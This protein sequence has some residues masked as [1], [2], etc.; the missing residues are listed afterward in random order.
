MSDHSQSARA[1]SQRFLSTAQDESTDSWKEIERKWIVKTIP[2]L[3]GCKRIEI[4][5]G[6]LAI[7]ADGTEV[8]IR[9]KGS[10]YFQTVKT[11]GS[12]VRTEIEIEISSEQYAKLWP[13]TVGRRAQKVRFEL[14]F[15]GLMIEV[16]VYGSSLA[17]LIIAEAEFPSPTDAARFD[18]PDWLAIEVTDDPRYK[19][20]NL[21]TSGRPA[22]NA[23][24]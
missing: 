24:G 4:D 12:M 7:G 9:R 1:N 15:N 11:D 21:A 10:Q 16:D 20:K 13:A 22:Q 19:N 5:Q 18:P 17:G 23:D 3:T 14:P 6:Y 2:D 8:R